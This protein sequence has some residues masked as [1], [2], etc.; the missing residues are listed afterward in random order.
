MPAFMTPDTPD[1]AGVI[2]SISQVYSLLN[3]SIFL[4]I[5]AAGFVIAFLGV[6]I[7]KNT[8]NYFM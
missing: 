8:I 5:A 3:L 2:N 6:V 1:M 4:A 7:A